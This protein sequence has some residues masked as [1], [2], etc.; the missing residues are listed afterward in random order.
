MSNNLIDVGLFERRASQSLADN[1]TAF[2]L[3]IC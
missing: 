1:L 3:W 2:F